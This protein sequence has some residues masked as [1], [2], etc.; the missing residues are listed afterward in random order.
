MP[1]A[2]RDRTAGIRT[3]HAEAR[4]RAAVLVIR[5]RNRFDTRPT[6]P[7][8]SPD[9]AGPAARHICAVSMVDAPAEEEVR[10][11]AM[12]ALRFGNVRFGAHRSMVNCRCTEVP[13][14]RPG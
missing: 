11:R 14:I 1:A 2:P 4:C 8:G 9:P 13:Y 12:R 6:R 10:C 7:G 3:A 5:F